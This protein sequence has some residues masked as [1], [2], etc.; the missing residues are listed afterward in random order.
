MTK[1]TDQKLTLYIGA[2]CGYCH[3]VMHFLS[4]NDID[5][6][7]VDVWSDKA[8]FEEMKKLSGSTQVPCLKID[9]TYMLESDDIIDQLAE[10]FIA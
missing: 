3:K 6:P 10:W 7:I 1:E 4:N 9:D 8:A 2:S 5:I